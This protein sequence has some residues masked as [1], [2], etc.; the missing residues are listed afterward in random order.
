MFITIYK[1]VF[2]GPSVDNLKI[3]VTGY[4]MLIKI[5]VNLCELKRE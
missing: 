4:K 3:K 1:L 5:K 2:E